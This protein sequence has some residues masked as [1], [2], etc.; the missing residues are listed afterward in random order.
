MK[1]KICVASFFALL[2]FSITSCKKFLSQEPDQALNE[3]SLFSN[4]I[5]TQ[6][7]LAQVYANIPDPYANRYNG[8]RSGPYNMIADDANWI[9]QQGFP[10]AVWSYSTAN[11]SVSIAAN[12]WGEWYKPIRNATDYIA[13]V[14][15]AN[16]VEVNA[17]LRT[18]YKA[19]ARAL[20]A[21]YYFWLMR[22]YGP[23]IIL[24][25]VIDV[26]S[27][28]ADL[29]RE[30][31]P[32]DTCINYVVSQLDSAYLELQ[33]ISSSTQPSSSALNNET[34]RITT[35][36]CKAYKEQA[37]LLAASPL[38]NG[39]TQLAG[40]KNQ[41]GTQL[42]NQTYDVNRWKLAADA[43][44]GFIDEFS[45]VYSL[46]TVANTDSF[47]AAYLACRDVVT[48]DWNKEW[49]FGKSLSGNVGY[50]Y[51]SFT[52]KLVGYSSSVV[53]QGGGYG[54]VNQSLVDAYFMK[55]GMSITD[56]GS[57]Y[58]TT[59]FTTFQAPGD[60]KARSTFNQWINREPRF[61]VGVTYNNSYWLNQGSSS[62][63]VIVDFTYNGNSGAVQSTND[64]SSTGYLL[65]KNIIQSNT[66][67][68]WVY[69]R[70][71]QIYLDYAEALNEYDPGNA[72]ILK[73]LNMIRVRAGIPAYG[74]GT[75]QIVAPVGQDAMREAIRRERRVELAHEEVR[76]FDLRRWKIA[77]TVLSQPVYGMNILANGDAFYQKTLEFTPRF[78]QR[79][80]LWPIPSE[81]IRKDSKLV[82][83]P[84][85]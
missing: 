55:N 42:I 54:A 68:G 70:L 48:A 57:G 12:L 73:Y 71:A 77:Q 39:N 49:I 64:R 47:T 32:F 74:S 76:Y 38:F 44:K 11:A 8:S 19:E 62:S 15:N 61:Y 20:R 4:L 72:D 69:L 18:H 65:R 25:N 79:D 51:Y 40:L 37:L 52:P 75:G 50:Y 43:A 29:M 14:D 84:G 3:D 35:G 78:Q 41:D 80:Y 6:N 59:G 34:G 66:S 58:Q 22:T 82:Q 5:N 26:N 46:Y 28:T 63:E 60:V 1:I 24:P 83:N 30:R 31:S 27:S 16:P 2:V 81:E 13:K 36:I 53:S 67:R 21:I 56:S 10:S 9:S 7:Y 45:G 85:W 17:F 23:V 33:S